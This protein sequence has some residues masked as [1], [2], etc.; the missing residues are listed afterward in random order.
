MTKSITGAA[1]AATGGLIL[2]TSAQAA[3][4]EI[5]WTG[6]VQNNCI[7]TLSTP[8]TL[9]AAADGITLGSQETG[10]AAAILAVIST[11]TRPTL[12]FT[13]PA[14]TGPAGWTGTP[15]VSMA[16]TSLSGLSQAYTTSATTSPQIGTLLDTLTINAKGV[17]ATGF[18]T[19]T[20]TITS[21]VTCQQ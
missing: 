11:G 14:M 12:A 16:Y 6:T 13:A 21:T 20:Y 17:N 3:P 10:G 8:G 4:T 1:L 19:G 2:A 9:A 15:T 18:I 7:L 5:R